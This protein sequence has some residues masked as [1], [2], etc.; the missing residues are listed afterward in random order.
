[1]LAQ[2]GLDRLEIAALSL[3]GS[4]A[5]G[6]AHESSDRDYRGIYIPA[7]ETVLA[8]APG[9]SGASFVPPPEEHERKDPD[10]VVFELGKFMR[11][12]AASNPNV[13]ELLWAPS[14]AHTREGLRLRENRTSFLSTRVKETYGGYARSQLRHLKNIDD[15]LAGEQ[16]EQE[17]ARKQ[18]KREKFARHLFRLFEQ[19]RQLL[20]TADMSIAVTDPVR[21]REQSL[22]PYAEIEAAFEQL[23]EE[24]KGLEGVLPERPDW[25]ALNEIALDLRLAHLGWPAA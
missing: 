5:Y 7:T 17:R 4:H 21:L 8:V 22:W 11:L 15:Y 10:L 3:V 19:G 23:D 1:M 25:D 24:M 6:L 16:D 12:A 20:T 2:T 18:K 9:G 13:L 14:L